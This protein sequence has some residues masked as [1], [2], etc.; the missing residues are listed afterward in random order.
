MLLRIL[1]DASFLSRPNAGSVVG[2]L[3]YLGLTDGDD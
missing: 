3:S 2:S 1:S